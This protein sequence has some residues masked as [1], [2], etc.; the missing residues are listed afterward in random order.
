MKYEK[1]YFKIYIIICGFFLNETT[2]FALKTLDDLLNNV[3]RVIVNPLL[4]FGFAAGIFLFLFG[5]LQIFIPEKL[6]GA[7]P[8]GATPEKGREH[9]QWGILGL[10]L[11]F[12]VFGVMK[13]LAATIGTVVP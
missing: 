7:F 1:R 10:F 11:M 5:M 3:N 2:I 8:G 6:R 4:M 9:M 12:G 13:F